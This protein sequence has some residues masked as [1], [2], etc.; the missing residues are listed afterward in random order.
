VYFKPPHHAKVTPT[1]ELDEIEI[2]SSNRPNVKLRPESR[3][4]DGTKGGP[5]PHSSSFPATRLPIR[6][7]ILR[8]EHEILT[9]PLSRTLPV[10]KSPSSLERPP[11]SQP[12]LDEIFPK[13]ACSIF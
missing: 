7:S 11:P 1:Y 2:E 4:S 5:L 10:L 9:V 6:T 13:I 8:K 3:S 12:N